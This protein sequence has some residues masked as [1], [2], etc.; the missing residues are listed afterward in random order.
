MS[1][2]SDLL[3]L[4]P[5]FA[6]LLACSAAQSDLVARGRK[7]ASNLTKRR[8]DPSPPITSNGISPPSRDTPAQTNGR[9]LALTKLQDAAEMGDAKAQNNLGVVYEMAQG[10]PWGPKYFASVITKLSDL[11]ASNE[12]LFRE[13]FSQ[14]ISRDYAKAAV[15]YRRAAEQ[16]FDCAQVN[17]G[18]LYTTGKGVSTDY[19][20]A[21]IWFR[22]AAEQGNTRA[23]CFLGELYS[24]GQGVPV[25]FE[26]AVFWLRRAADRFVRSAQYEL[27]LLYSKNDQGR[28][29]DNV[30]AYYWL[31]LADASVS[32][33]KQKK[34][35]A[36]VDDK[37]IKARMDAASKLSP[38]ERSEVEK[39]A[40]RWLASHSR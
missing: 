27:G 16:G 6:S 40:N 31:Y 23:Q 37:F 35:L 20:Q 12:K 4:P 7:E 30:E 34:N 39:R 15:W 25:D 8:S 13:L 10:F 33:S 29:P 32:F 14:S 24:K 3:K 1:D 18:T 28:S 5:P 9:S 17:L 19:A 21:A 22:R 36:A 2:T 26:Q 38:S 11:H